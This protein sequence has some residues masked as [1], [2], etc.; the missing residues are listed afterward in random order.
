MANFAEL[1][2]YTSKLFERYAPEARGNARR[3][4][5]GM[6]SGLT[7]PH[8][9]AIGD[10]IGG[11]AVADR[12]DEDALIKRL[13]AILTPVEREHVM[14]AF[15]VW[16]DDEQRIASRMGADF[17]RERPD[18]ARLANPAPQQTPGKVE[19]PASA[20]S[21]MMANYLTE[22]LETGGKTPSGRGSLLATLKY[23]SQNDVR[24]R[25][26]MRALMLAALSPAHRAGVGQ[27]IGRSVVS[28][29][30][31][32][33]TLSAEID[34]LLSAKE[35]QRVVDAFATFV[36]EQRKARSEMLKMFPGSEMQFMPDFP[37][38]PQTTGMP[39]P[40]AILWRALLV[41]PPRGFVTQR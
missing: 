28:S 7:P 24:I 20:A 36:T 12:Q 6:V 27:A 4:R 25:G 16:L 5:V 40:G 17:I 9:A 26:Q 38:I 32:D 19:L 15:S 39:N 21:R 8:R 30:A 14:A 23:G 3:L 11:Y 18:L 37:N 29:T 31:D 2:K 33:G 13:D 22:G 34:G 41:V 10:A 1:T 35:K